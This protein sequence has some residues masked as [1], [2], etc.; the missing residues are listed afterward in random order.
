M[1]NCDSKTSSVSMRSAVPFATFAKF[2]PLLILKK[3]VG[4][5]EFM[6]NEAIITK[7]EAHFAKK[8]RKSLD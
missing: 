2:N 1:G 8:V 5:K 3:L 4:G 6:S 7:T